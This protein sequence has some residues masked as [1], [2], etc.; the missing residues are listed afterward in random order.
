M[1]DTASSIVEVVTA[2]VSAVGP[3]I[4]KAIVEHGAANAPIAE[5][6]RA[7]VH[8]ILY[9]NGGSQ[10]ASEVEHAADVAAVGHLDTVPP[11]KA[12]P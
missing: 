5:D 10:L 6:E 7:K 8:A 4:A 11:P 9:P 2:I 12:A 3:E 1:S